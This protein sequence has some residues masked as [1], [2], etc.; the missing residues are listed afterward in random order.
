[1]KQRAYK[2]ALFLLTA[3]LIVYLLPHDRKLNYSYS[4]GRPWKHE[5]LTTAY[6]FPILKDKAQVEAEQDSVLR[7]FQPFY[8]L[9]ASVEARETERLLAEL[10]NTIPDTLLT[11]Y[12]RFLK[13]ELQRI[14][15]V[16]I[17]SAEEAKQ[18][19]EGNLTAINIVQA[20]TP[21][22]RSLQDV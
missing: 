18:L 3:V 22:S 20:R 21:E 12:S 11:A 5:L 13:S 14:Y 2:I 15:S 9:D 6:A 1:M 16:G 8:S 17:I 19:E 10:S 7:A 4:L